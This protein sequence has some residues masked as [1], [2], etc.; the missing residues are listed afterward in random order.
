MKFNVP[1]NPRLKYTDNKN[2]KVL[3]LRLSQAMLK[4]LKA[5]SADKN[6]SVSEIVE[7]IIDQYLQ[8]QD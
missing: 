6:R 7:L 2:T 8:Q 3:S 4:R 5:D 1:A